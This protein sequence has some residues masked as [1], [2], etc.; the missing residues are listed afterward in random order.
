MKNKTKNIIGNLLIAAGVMSIVCFMWINCSGRIYQQLYSFYYEN[1]ADMQD[2]GDDFLSYDM[3]PEAL[4]IGMTLAYT[5]ADPGLEREET[6]IEETTEKEEQ[7]TEA[8]TEA[9]TAATE[10]KPKEKKIIPVFDTIKYVDYSD[11]S[12]YQSYDMGLVVKRMGVRSRIVNGTGP[13]ALKKAPGLYES[14]QLPDAGHGNVII[15]AH[16]DVY[17]AWFY[18]IDKIREGDK[19]KIYFEDKI[20]VYDYKDTNIVEKNDWSL[21][22]EGDEQMLILTSCHPKGTSEKRI[23]VRAVLGE[24]QQR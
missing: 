18:S 17:G 14:S 19:L 22:E 2:D 23:I 12:G 3:L 21:L 10:A 6:Y 11:R 5:N 15:A 4:R 7:T 24:I 8:A 16:R 13:D 1:I 9:T 20:Y